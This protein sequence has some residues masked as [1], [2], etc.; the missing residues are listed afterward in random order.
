MLKTH[1]PPT[2]DCECIRMPLGFDCNA[3]DGDLKILRIV[4]THETVAF[5][6]TFSGEIFSI[7]MD[8]WHKIDPDPFIIPSNFTF[9]CVHRYLLATQYCNKL[10]SFNIRT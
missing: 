4:Q 2:I 9:E 5:I 7:R 10:M 6:S 3:T 1:F 8:V